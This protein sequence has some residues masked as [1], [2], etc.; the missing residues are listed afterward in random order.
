MRKYVKPRAKFH[1]LKGAV[2]LATE[3]GAVENVTITNQ[4]GKKSVNMLMD[5]WEEDINSSKNE[6]SWE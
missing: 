1:E 6:S 2:V 3:S 5:V 4:D